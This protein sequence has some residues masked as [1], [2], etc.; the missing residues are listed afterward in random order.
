VVLLG[1]VGIVAGFGP[2]AAAEISHRESTVGVLFGVYYL[3]AAAAAV[4]AGRLMD[5]RG[6]RSGLILGYVAIAA[7]GLVLAAASAARSVP[8]LLAG[9]AVLGA[10]AGA[11][12]LGRAAVADMYPP[13]RRGRAV[14]LL[15]V[16]GT[17]GAV[18][19]PLLAA[20]L[21]E[22]AQGA[23]GDPLAVPWLGTTVLALVAVACV[24]ALRPDPRDL[25][26]GAP[27]AEGD[28]SPSRILRLRPVVTATVTIG[29]V[30]AAMVTF[31]GVI[32]A[33]LHSHRRP[34]ITVS[35][36]VSFHLFGMFGFSHAVG[37]VLDRVGRPRTLVAGVV[38]T[39]AGVAVSMLVPGT[40]A[41]G[42]ALLLIGVGW[43]ACY[44][45]STAV[46]SDVTAPAE[47]AGA[48]GL[49]DLVAALA[50]G[51]GVLGGAALFQATG[52]GVLGWV[53]AA[54]L[55]VPLA[56][57]IILRRPLSVEA[58]RNGGPSV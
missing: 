2:V 52:F 38:A 23:V 31:M 27:R 44:L 17:V 56:L 9:G 15:V 41:S 43:S 46:V 37:W 54:L 49:V 51:V 50:A 58:R 28:R 19:G 3:S 55:S 29:I 7:S 30:Q 14:G 21:Y 13:E 25:A 35:L 12:L 36:V 24:A 6:R 47:R 4:T 20:L 48:L 16:A 5:R 22:L 33:V 1:A 45:G 34:A 40:P 39:L 26:V 18:G 10:G 11:A 8:G 42:V 53:T 57:L 32:P